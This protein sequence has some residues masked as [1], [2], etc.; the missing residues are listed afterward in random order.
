MRRGTAIGKELDFALVDAGNKQN[1]LFNV[2]TM[3]VFVKMD[4]IL[5]VSELRSVL[6]KEKTGKSRHKPRRCDVVTRPEPA[7]MIYPEHSLSFCELN[8]AAL[9][10]VM[11]LRLCGLYFVDLGCVSNLRKSMPID[12]KMYPPEDYDSCRIGKLGCT[13]N[14]R[15]RF[16]DLKRDYGEF[17]STF[18]FRWFLLV[19]NE[20]NL[21]C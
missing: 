7:R 13:E 18:N 4:D 21:S 10:Q 11:N 6:L 15:Q 17:S 20:K 19:P 16:S 3:T 8:N 1:P 5:N 9:N 2:S 14:F 12:E